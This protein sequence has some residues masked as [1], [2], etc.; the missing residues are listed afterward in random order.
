[1]ITYSENALKIYNEL[2]NDGIIDSSG[3]IKI[4]LHGVEFNL[5]S[6]SALGDIIQDWVYYWSKKQ[7]IYI[8]QNLSSQE[9]PDFFLSETNENNFLEIKT[10]DFSASANFDVANFDAYIRSLTIKPHKIYADY[11]IFGYTLENG[12]LTIKKIWL[13]KIWE[14][15]CPSEKQPIK[16][17]VKQNKFINIRP[18]SWDS[19]RAKFKPFNNINDFITALDDTIQSY[20]FLSVEIDK[21][22]WKTNVLTSLGL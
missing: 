20:P 11:L 18:A 14:I 6:K 9:F 12:L 1:M 7:G 4:T 21:L 10:F 16:G 17:Q 2:L 3:N 19:N 13:K 5:N 8:R 15:T 22:T